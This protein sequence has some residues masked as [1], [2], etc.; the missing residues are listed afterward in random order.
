[1]KQFRKFNGLSSYDEFAH[2]MS[3]DFHIKDCNFGGDECALIYPSKIGIKWT[4]ERIYYRSVIIRKS[5]GA[6]ISCGFPKFFNYGECDSISSDPNNFS[7]WIIQEKLDGSLIIVSRYRDDLIIRTRGQLSVASLKNVDELLF[8]FS[9]HPDIKHNRWLYSNHSML[10]EHLSVENRIVLK[11]DVS[12]LVFIGMI[13]NDSYLSLSPSSP[14]FG[15]I[16]DEIGCETPKLF[17]FSSIADMVDNCKK[18]T[19]QEGYVLNYNH[20]L[21]RL[22]LKGDEYLFLHKAISGLKN[23]NSIIELFALAGFPNAYENFHSYVAQKFDFEIAESIGAQM[24]EI[25]AYWQIVLARMESMRKKILTFGGRDRKSA[26]LEINA[27]FSGDDRSMA[28]SFLSGKSIP[29]SKLID[30]IKIGF[31]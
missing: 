3:S 23:I 9:L 19:G 27:M 18:L 1:M 6:P 8:T 25:I 30:L 17:H 15:Q 24:K 16:A 26:A 20:G 28:F 13:E 5:D 14:S 10:F 21:E 4:E 22:K 7:D 2:S 29:N 31:K 11:H 12:K